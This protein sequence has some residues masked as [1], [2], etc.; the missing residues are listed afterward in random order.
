MKKIFLFLTLFLSLLFSSSIDKKI[1]ANKRELSIK[2]K[3]YNKMDKKLSTLAKKILDAKA[4]NARIDKKLSQLEKEIK[5]NQ[6]KFNDL[7]A[8]KKELDKEL[9]ELNKKIKAKREKFI[10]LVA[11]KFSMALVLDEIKKPTPKSVMLQETYKVYAKENERKIEK[12]KEEIEKLNEKESYFIDKQQNLKRAIDDYK[13]KKEEYKAQKA[14][15]TKLIQELARDKSIY[16]KRFDK[17]RASRRAL[18]RKLAKLK[19]IKQDREN[20]KKAIAVTSSPKKKKKKKQRDIKVASY[21][22]GKTISPLSGSKLIKKFGTYIDPIYKFRIFNKS[23]TLKAP[24][25]GAKVKSVLDGKI[26]FAE[27][28]GGMLGKVV[29]IS[30]PNNLHTIY[31]K[32]S[33]L[34]P[35]IHVGKRVKKGSV[36]GKVDSTLMFEVTKNNKHMNPLKLIRL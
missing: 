30:H 32:L 36:I 3:E 25:Q 9:T 1:K 21:H 17:I 23:I 26:V 24:Y 10:S 5:K 35:G 34:A 20:E 28:S 8:Q 15:K 2:Q 13:K 22:G 4:Q 18:Q 27:N 7:T 16:R 31:A 12:L 6:S 14:K 19:I 33:R 11:E 29:I